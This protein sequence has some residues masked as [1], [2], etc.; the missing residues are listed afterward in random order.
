MSIADYSD[1]VGT[2][3]EYS[4]REDFAHMI[5][6]FV[7]FLENKLNRKLRVGDME[8]I[9]TLTTDSAGAADLPADYLEMRELVNA[10][11]KPLEN[12]PLTA[13]DDTFRFRSGTPEGY[14]IVGS[15]L[16][17]LPIAEAEFLIT[18]YEKIPG[19]SVTNTSNWLLAGH[20]NV[21]LYGVLAEVHGWAA[22]SGRDPEG[23]TKAAAASQMMGTEL[24]A[25]ESLDR[26]QRYSNSRMMLRGVTP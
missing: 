12:R 4:G 26:S 16:Y 6:R 11:G 17:V 18:Y 15:V 10:T 25:L 19:L 8:Q 21:Y 3:T 20:P 5:P 23:A 9:A 1:L 24:A 22:A 13:L 7:S 2:V 14:A